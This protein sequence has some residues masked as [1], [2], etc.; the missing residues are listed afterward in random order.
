IEYSRKNKAYFISYQPKDNSNFQ[1]MMEAFDMFNSLNLAEDLTPIVHLEK[2]RPQGTENLYGLLHAIKNKLQIKFN[3]QKFWE[4]EITQRNAEPYGLKEF[5]NRWYVLALD[6]KDSIVKS[7][8]MD[9]ITEFDVTKK[10]FEYPIVYNIEDN[11]RYSFGIMYP[12]EDAPQ[13]IILSFTPVQ[14]KYMKSLPLHST[15]E[16]LVD[17]AKEVQ[18]KLKLFITYDFKMELLSHGDEVKV[19]QPK[20]L[21]KEIKAAHEKAYKRYSSKE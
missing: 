1:R 7:F 2:R 16:I 6:S 15:Q 19:L 12:E 4:E 9:R 21:A 3:Y 18:I 20:S 5:K 11:Y 13:E 8:A 14:G 17:N 10:K